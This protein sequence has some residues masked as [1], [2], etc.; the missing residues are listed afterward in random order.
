MWSS[1]CVVCGIDVSVSC[2]IRWK[3]RDGEEDMCSTQY[4]SQNAL[5]AQGAMM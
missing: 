5:G 2:D 4:D 1:I 3:V